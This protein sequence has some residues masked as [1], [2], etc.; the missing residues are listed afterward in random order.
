MPRRNKEDTAKLRDEIIHMKEEGMKPTGISQE[1]EIS[2]VYV[3]RV[4]NEAGF[5]QHRREIDEDAVIADY[6]GGEIRVLDVC[7]KHE[8]STLKLYQILASHDIDTS[9]RKRAGQLAVELAVSRYENEPDT[10]VWKILKE[11][12]IPQPI[13]HK[14][15]HDREIPLRRVK[16]NI[17]PTH[18]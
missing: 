12:G 8:I 2:E 10:P 15:L 13:L 14:A 11:T 16:Y 4:L 3:R 9:S 7:R 5:V 18:A 17:Q 6:I 1:L